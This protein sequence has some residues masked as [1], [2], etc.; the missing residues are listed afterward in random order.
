MEHTKPLNKQLLASGHYHY[1]IYGFDMA[2]ESGSQA[3]MPPSAKMTA[4]DGEDDRFSSTSS[5]VQAPV[6]HHSS[7]S[8]GDMVLYNE[9]PQYSG[10]VPSYCQIQHDGE[11]HISVSPPPALRTCPSSA[12][13]V[14]CARSDT[15]SSVGPTCRICDSANDGCNRLIS[16]CRCSGTSKFV[17]ERCL[18]VSI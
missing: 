15:N 17:H 6:F 1:G 12:S 13:M 14:S 4:H 7:I 9:V 18:N 8:S 2:Q 16:P 10:A 11:V 3:H 5:D